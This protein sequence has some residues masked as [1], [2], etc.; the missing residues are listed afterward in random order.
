M[1]QEFVA[2]LADPSPPSCE[3]ERRIIQAALDL[4]AEHGF[5]GATTEAIARRAEVTEKTLFRRF[6]SK[7]HL[8]AKTVYPAMLRMLEPLAYKSLHAV[9][10]SDYPSLRQLLHGVIAERIQF[11]REHPEILK[12]LAQ[13]LLLHPDFREAFAEF[14]KLRLL[15]ENKKML[16]RARAR[17]E[18]C[19]LPDLAV[20]RAII[21]L[22]VGLC[23]HTLLFVP[24]KKGCDAKEAEILVD[25]L[26]DGISARSQRARRRKTPKRT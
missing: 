6:G 20:L 2:F 25:I 18:L 14:W 5:G 10:N 22:T 7:K 15:P 11:N 3:T 12:L 9:L 23:L 26:L 1:K 16:R 17:G 13:G 24:G 8:F 19:D 4:F 21:S